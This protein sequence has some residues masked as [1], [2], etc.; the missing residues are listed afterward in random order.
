MKH[1]PDFYKPDD[2]R[3]Q[4]ACLP[5]A[6]QEDIIEEFHDKHP[7]DYRSYYEE[8]ISQLPA[9]HDHFDLWSYIAACIINKHGEPE[10]WTL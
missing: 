2:D 5:E 10:D 1:H 6:E 3:P 4:F 8:A 7:E 9:G